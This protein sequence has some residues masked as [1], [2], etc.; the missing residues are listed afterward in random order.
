MGRDEYNAQKNLSIYRKTIIYGFLDCSGRS[1]YSPHD[2]KRGCASYSLTFSVR[3][4]F[5]VAS[6]GA[7]A[8]LSE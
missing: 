5:F 2:A 3:R 4:C 8:T 1:V 6:T 7:E